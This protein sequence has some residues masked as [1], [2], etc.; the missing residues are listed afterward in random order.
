MNCTFAK[1]WEEEVNH[2]YLTHTGLAFTLPCHPTGKTI[3]S[4]TDG[5]CGIMSVISNF[6]F[7]DPKK[8]RSLE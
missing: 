7:V 4:S 8:S 6:V 5:M 1:G 2:F 3:V